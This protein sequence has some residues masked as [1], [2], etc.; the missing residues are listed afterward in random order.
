MATQFRQKRR[1]MRRSRLLSN[2][3]SPTRMRVCSSRSTA[4][5]KRRSG[6]A[7]TTSARPCYL[8]TIS[9]LELRQANTQIDAKR[10]HP[11]NAICSGGP[12]DETRQYLVFM[13]GSNLEHCRAAFTC[14]CGVRGDSCGQSAAF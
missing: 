12:R 7:P 5:S 8:D 6:E 14:G 4:A 1:C 10:P 9:K 2:H 13:N 11:F 3:S